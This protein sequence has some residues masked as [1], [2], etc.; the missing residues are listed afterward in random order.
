MLSIWIW[1]KAHLLTIF[2][3]AK[4]IEFVADKTCDILMGAVTD[5]IRNG[6][7]RRAVKKVYKQTMAEFA[8]DTSIYDRNAKYCTARF[9]FVKTHPSKQEMIFD[10]YPE[11]GAFM[12][13]FYENLKNNDETLRI[14]GAYS[15][16]GIYEYASDTNRMVKQLVENSLPNA[17]AA[18]KDNINAMMEAIEQLKL[19][20]AIHILDRMEESLNQYPEMQQQK[21]VYATLYFLKGNALEFTD[22]KKALENYKRAYAYNPYLP[23]LKEHYLATAFVVDQIDDKVKQL[24]EELLRDD[25]NNVTAIAVKTLAMTDDPE[26]AVK[27]IDKGFKEDYRFKWLVMMWLNRH[28]DKI[29]AIEAEVPM[30]YDKEPQDLTAKNYAEWMYVLNAILNQSVRSDEVDIYGNTH[31][32]PEHK[33]QLETIGK[34]Y[35]LAEPTEV[36]NSFVSVR[37]YYYYLQFREKRDEGAF[38]KLLDFTEEDEVIERCKYS[39]LMFHDE[40]DKAY[41]VL[42]GKYQ[43]YCARHKMYAAL[44]LGD[45]EKMKE[46]ICDM[47]GHYQISTLDILTIFECIKQHRELLKDKEFIGTLRCGWYEQ[48]TT[49]AIVTLYLDA[50]EGNM[51]NQRFDDLLQGLDSVS[52]AICC[53]LWADAADVE[54]AWTK[55]QG[56]FNVDDSR[57]Q[58]ETLVYFDLLYTC[59]THN[60]EFCEM[61]K[62]LREKRGFVSLQYLMKEVNCYCAISDYDSALIPQEILFETF[63]DN[64]AMA[65]NYAMILL[66]TGDHDRIKN[67]IQALTSI[68]YTSTICIKNVFYA[69]T[70][71][72]AY[73]EALDFIYPYAKDEAFAAIGDFYVMITISDKGLSKVLNEV[74]PEVA[75][76]CTVQLTNADENVITEAHEKSEKTSPLL[77][78]KVGDTVTFNHKEYTITNIGSKYLALMFSLR[79]RMGMPGN[80]YTTQTIS[81][82]KDEK[83]GKLLKRMEA[84]LPKNNYTKADFEKDVQ[85]YG[86]GEQSLYYFM[87]NDV[88]FSCAQLV[89]SDFRKIV[90]PYL[91]TSVALEDFRQQIGEITDFVI[92]PLSVVLLAYLSKKHGFTYG[93][94]FLI[95]KSEK[96]LFVNSR[97]NY[98]RYPSNVNPIS[99]WGVIPQDMDKALGEN[100]Q[101]VLDYLNQWIDE[102]CKVE[103]VKERMAEPDGSRL[104]VESMNIL[105]DCM[106]LASHPYNMLITEDAGIHSLMNGMQFF[107]ICSETYL[108]YF[109]GRGMEV[110]QSLLERNYVVSMLDADT[111]FAEYDKSIK[112]QSNRY[113]ICK[114]VISQHP[115]MWQVITQFIA[116]ILSK[117]I[118]LP[119]DTVEIKRLLT[120][121]IRILGEKRQLLLLHFRNQHLYDVKMQLQFAQLFKEACVMT[122]NLA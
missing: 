32:H 101:E 97:N 47:A 72:E 103:F 64:E 107:A 92:D 36:K 79:D 85:A 71:E 80:I 62:E 74:Q 94:K 110:N 73:Q 90:F 5:K 6:R 117:N 106:M 57:M 15:I 54:Y 68:N 10:S 100:Y 38:A 119:Q 112:G 95:P 118:L 102:N 89:L 88:V 104:K 84:L 4:A 16:T 76:G 12:K 65:G 1:I 48:D 46:S 26:A 53:R 34:F 22:V 27:S 18:L 45:A 96:D 105:V 81:T 91:Q 75:E 20:T 43:P 78:C 58:V 13:R 55:M 83:P 114:M 9:N 40:Y 19:K 116:M 113:D 25:E 7:E 35:E 21:A 66:R 28:T 33:T 99:F 17:G 39:A 8:N 115:E 93:R 56:H 29:Q 42:S 69:L 67:H 60:E 44:K 31:I 87:T 111:L 50:I 98:L 11:L 61:S 52:Y 37:V 108:R 51:S 109:E 30:T 77:G 120:E 59:N 2:T 49:A 63:A 82:D 121:L 70:E 86:R 14:I 122:D 23:Q 41:D 24:T 3:G